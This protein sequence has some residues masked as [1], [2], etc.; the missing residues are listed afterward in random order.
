MSDLTA[1]Q[2]ELDTTIQA[3]EE[4]RAAKAEAFMAARQAE[5]EARAAAEAAKSDAQKAADL[6]AQ[7]DAAKAH[8]AE[9]QA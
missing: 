1:L 5:E 8:L 4:A 7:I 6:Q 9:L 2:A 3:I